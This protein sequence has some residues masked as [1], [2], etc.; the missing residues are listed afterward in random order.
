MAMTNGRFTVIVYIV[1]TSNGLGQ[2][3]SESGVLESRACCAWGVDVSSA[4]GHTETDHTSLY[5][6]LTLFQQI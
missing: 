1:Q 4:N 2:V 5:R 6:E 3:I